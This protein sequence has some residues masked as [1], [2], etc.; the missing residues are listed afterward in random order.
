MVFV[1][2]PNGKTICLHLNPST[3]TLH[4][5]KLSLHSKSLIPPSLQRLIL[6]SPLR[7]LTSQDS[8]LL[9]ELGVG[10]N[11]TITLHVPFLGGMQ[12]PGVPPTRPRLEFLNS[13]PPPN[14][15]AGLGRGATG[16]TTRSDIGPARAAPDLPDRSA[17][18]IGGAGAP[19]TGAGRGR[20]KGGEEEED[21]EGDDK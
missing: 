14:Y 16:F 6:S 19:S 8:L 1:F 20:G 9:S 5:L 3:A 7:L 12:A 15:V 13:K 2:A 18:T 10:P 21:D 4:D 11:S 17:T